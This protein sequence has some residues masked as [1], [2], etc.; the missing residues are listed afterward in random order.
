MKGNK[1][2]FLDIGSQY[3]SFYTDSCF[4]RERNL[5]VVRRGY[6]LELLSCGSD[7]LSMIKSLPEHSYVVKP[8]ENGSITNPEALEL[9]LKSLFSKYFK[10]RIIDK[11]QVYCL[12]PCGLSIAERESLEKIISTTGYKDIT[13]VE[14]ILGLLPYTDG[15]ATAVGIL[16]ASMSDIGIIDSSGI[17]SGLSINLGGDSINEKIKEIVLDKKN[18][19][20]SGTT[21]EKIKINLGSLYENDKS[22]YEVVGQDILD[23][24]FR[25]IDVSADHIRPAILHAYK[26]YVDIIESI[27]TTIPNRSLG[28]V[29][30]NG[31]LLAGGGA[32]MRGAIDF[33][34]KYLK[35]PIRILERPEIAHLKGL[36]NLVNDKTGKYG[37]IFG[38][39]R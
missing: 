24:Q 10:K 3:I 8:L 27:L 9:V 4:L 14:S 32:E 5:A 1:K 17:V 25:K 2:I 19:K 39:N 15:K 33:F 30:L 13:L 28:E 12:I 16:G 23:Q 37:E 31:L 20:I 11:C 18:L 21:S 34:A 35:L 22:L 36:S 7:T 26:R 38:N 6:G 29:S